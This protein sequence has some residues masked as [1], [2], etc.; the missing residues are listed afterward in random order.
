[1]RPND[2]LNLVLVEQCEQF[3]EVWLSFHES[4]CE[5]TPPRLFVLTHRDFA[6]TSGR[7]VQTTGEDSLW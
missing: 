6:K 3:F 4:A 5:A 2:V 7:V 1:M